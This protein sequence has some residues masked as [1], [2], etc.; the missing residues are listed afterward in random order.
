MK[1]QDRP[2]RRET[3]PPPMS[4]ERD[5]IGTTS[6]QIWAAVDDYYRTLTDSGDYTPSFAARRAHLVRG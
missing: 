3:D 6:Q 2:Y 5:P 4:E 1:R